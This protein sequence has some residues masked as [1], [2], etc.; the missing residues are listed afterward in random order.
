MKKS[1]IQL[2]WIIINIIIS[3]NADTNPEHR[4]EKRI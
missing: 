1:A 2:E 4:G 3:C